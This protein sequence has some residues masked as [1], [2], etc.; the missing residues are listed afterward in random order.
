[1]VPKIFWTWGADFESWA[2]SSPPEINRLLSRSVDHP[3][4]TRKAGAWFKLTI[5][6]FPYWFG[7]LTGI[8]KSIVRTWQHWKLFLFWKRSCK[9][10]HAATKSRLS[11]YFSSD[12]WRVCA[13]MW[14]LLSPNSSRC[15]VYAY[16][17]SSRKTRVCLT[18]HTDTVP[19]I[20]RF[21]RRTI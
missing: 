15:N 12:T 1:M 6:A 3:Y 4:K 8:L 10:R 17:G 18:A 19:R 14:S 13:I 5:A 7:C 21:E 9:F 2:Y 16:L 11:V 20:S